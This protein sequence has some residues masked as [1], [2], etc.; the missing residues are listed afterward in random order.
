MS[1]FKLLL[2]PS[3]AVEL[4]ATSKAAS[5]PSTMVNLSTHIIE[6]PV[7][8]ERLVT[9]YDIAISPFINR[10]GLAKLPSSDA[11]AKSANVLALLILLTTPQLY[12][13]YLS[14]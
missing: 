6:V 11:V 13:I 4:W 12:Q 9:L 10:L 3:G 7:W 2:N 8:P 1:I 14:S 5:A